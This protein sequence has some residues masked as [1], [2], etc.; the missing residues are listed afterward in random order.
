MIK[1]AFINHFAKKYYFP[2]IHE[3]IVKIYSY[4]NTNV[5]FSNLLLPKISYIYLFICFDSFLLQ[6]G[7][8]DK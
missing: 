3:K 1:M 5:S 2:C 7:A 6:L 4:C 8:A